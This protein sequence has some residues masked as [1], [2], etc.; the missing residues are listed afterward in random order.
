M[1]AKKKAEENTEP[2][3]KISIGI[4]ADEYEIVAEKL[5]IEEVNSRNVR[6]ALGLTETKSK[7]GYVSKIKELIKGKSKEEQKELYDQLSEE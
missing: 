2:L 4:Y 6:V 5:D 3:E 1:P 7:T